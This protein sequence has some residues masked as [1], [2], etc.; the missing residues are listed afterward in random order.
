MTRER[1]LSTRPLDGK[2]G[3]LSVHADG[4]PCRVGCEFCYLGARVADGAG[5]DLLLLADALA[6]LEY[7]E[8]AFSLSEPSVEAEVLACC[9]AGAAARGRPLAVTTTL[10][11]AAARPELLDGAARVN[12]SVDPRKGPR[13]VPA[14]VDPRRIDAIAAALK[15][16]APVEIVLIVSLVSAEFAGTLLDGLLAELVAL[17][18]VDKVA[19]NGL[20]PPPPWCDRAFWL[21]ALAALRPLLAREL[22]RRLFLD[23]YVAARILGLGGCP[24]RADLTPAAAPTLAAPTLAAPTPAARSLGLAFRGCVYQPAPD[25]V[26][27]DG[28]TLARRLRTFTPPPVCPFPI[29]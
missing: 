15:S 11:I 20:K 27:T 2:L 23:C 5:P 28:E 26:A 1:G 3:V 12:L 19:L 4:R 18:H 8:L 17:P 29:D 6:R 9:A 25:F 13:N 16:R 24:A 7:D 14:P 21:R 10:A 22:D